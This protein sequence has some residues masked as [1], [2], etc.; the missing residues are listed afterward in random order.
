MTTTTVPASTLCKRVAATVAAHL[1]GRTVEIGD[2][3]AGIHQT[4][5]IESPRRVR[6]SYQMAAAVIREM[7]AHHGVT[8]VTDYAGT[9]TAVTFA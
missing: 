7:K 3:F 6:V 4:Y 9:P 5:A 8:T 2:V 1:S